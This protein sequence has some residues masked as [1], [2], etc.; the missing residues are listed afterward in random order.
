MILRRL[1][2]NLRTQNWT[3]I[4][5]ELFIVIIGV[6][7]G[8][9]VSNWNADRLDRADTARLLDQLRPELRAQVDFYD[10]A[11]A[12]YATTR[13]F[14][15]VALAG[16][17]DDPRVNDSEFVIAAYQ[18]SQIQGIGTNSSTWANI[19]GAERLRSIEQPSI[20]RDL[21][22]LMYSD[23]SSIG[24]NAVDTPYR[25]NVRR[26][27]PIEIQDAIRTRCGDFTPADRPN[28]VLLPETCS[29]RL[30]AD[31]AAAAA[32]ALRSHP[33]L[34]DDLQWHV[35]AEA[36]FLANLQVFELTTHKLLREFQ[37]GDRR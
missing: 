19:F 3:A 16:W 13:R 8:T 18:A 12:Y 11:K 7:I 23:N 6:F 4:T 30:P 20:R 37:G 27:I 29:L 9:Q 2:H 10:T 24:I 31:Q 26:I 17:A 1:T 25:R 28:V 34:V 15:N 36:A 32:Q 14:A 33:D 22:F 21:S 5:I 35:A